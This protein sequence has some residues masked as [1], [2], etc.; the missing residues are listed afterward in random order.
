M[1]NF[2]L[3]N[4]IMHDEDIVGIQG[5]VTAKVTPD[6]IIEMYEQALALEDEEAK[7]AMLATVDVLREHIGE[8]LVS[9]IETITTE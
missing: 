2:T 3:Y 9:D 4:S 7:S 8:V 5:R 1:Y 6:F